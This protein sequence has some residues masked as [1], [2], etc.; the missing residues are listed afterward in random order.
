MT[1]K[2][3]K[4]MAGATVIMI[5]LLAACGGEK[6]SS[7]EFMTW[8]Q[9]NQSY[10]QTAVSFPFNLP[11]GVTFPERL[12]RPADGQ[13]HL[14]QSGV[15]GMQAYF[16]YQCAQEAIA[17]EYQTSDP[18]RANQALDAIIEMNRTDFWQTHYDDSAGVWSGILDKAR[19]G[20]YSALAGF[21]DG[22]CSDD[23]TQGNLK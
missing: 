11:E 6:D 21:Y 18:V 10:Q 7:D 14:Y 5:S 2:S 19:L 20:D 23:W 15:G 3:P 12:P 17:L 8:D 9:M 4:L 13:M 1:K 22:D 16:F